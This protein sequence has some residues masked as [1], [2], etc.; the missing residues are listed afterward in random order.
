MAA[1][2]LVG[3]RSGAA[4]QLFRRRNFASREPGVI[5]VFAIVGTVAILLLSLYIYRKV[6]ARRAART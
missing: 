2:Q 6:N 4:H 5:V 3:P 1:M